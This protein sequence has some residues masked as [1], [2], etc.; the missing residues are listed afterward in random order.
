MQYV[1]D[2]E[3]VLGKNIPGER[4]KVDPN[5]FLGCEKVR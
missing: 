2:F 4:F 5:P 3:K 1:P